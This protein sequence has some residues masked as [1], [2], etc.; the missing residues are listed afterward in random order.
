MQHIK[1]G[2]T[3][4][5][6]Y[7]QCNTETR[8]CPHFCSGKSISITYC[9]L[10]SLRIEHAMRHSV[11]CGL[12]GFAEFFHIISQAVRFSWKKLLNIKC[13]FR[14]CLQIL[15]HTFLILRSTE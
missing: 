7:V 9:V 10:I 6:I 12:S 15:S 13:V 14:I 8:S 5:A 11:I 1:E 4:Q 3:T 2:L